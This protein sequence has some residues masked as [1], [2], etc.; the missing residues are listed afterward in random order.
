MPHARVVL[1]H[2]L[3]TA[4]CALADVRATA[5]YTCSWPCRLVPPR[6][7][8]NPPQEFVTRAVVPGSPGLHLYTAPPK[9]V[10]Q[11]PKV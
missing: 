1:C 5:P 11:Q 7:C 8:L 4:P 10:L 9:A 6:Q 2:S 3:K